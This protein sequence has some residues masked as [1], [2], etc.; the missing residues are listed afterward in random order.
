LN[1]QLDQD[2][3]VS[4]TFDVPTFDYHTMLSHNIYFNLNA[5]DKINFEDGNRS[6]LQTSQ[7]QTRPLV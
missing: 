2:P 4:N 6:R 3:G 1:F 5:K 7:Q